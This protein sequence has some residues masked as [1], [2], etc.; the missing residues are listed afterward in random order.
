VN[1]TILTVNTGSS[2]I[3]LD[4]FRADATS[5][6][7]LEASVTDIGLPAS[8]VNVRIL[9]REVQT[10]K[11]AIAD[12]AAAA[13]VLLAQLAKSTALY[14]IAAIGYR[15][16]HGGSAYS[17]PQL[18]TDTVEQQLQSFAAYDP[19]HAP[20][21]L[22]LIHLLRQRFPDVP[23]VACFDTVFSHDMPRVAQLLPLP[24]KYEAMGLRRYG[25]HGLSYTYLLEAFR[26]AAGA[27]AADGRVIFAHLGSGASLMATHG[28]KPVDTTMGF[29]P[30]SG[31]VMSS[32]SGD[33]DPGILGYL[34]EQTGMSI[35]QYNHMINFESGLLGVSDLS[36]DM[37]TLLEHEATNPQA[38]EAVNLFVYQ[39]KKAIGA[40]A[41][42]LGGLDSLIFSGGIGEQSSILRAR[43][44]EGLDFLGIELNP[45]NNQRHAELIS[46]PAGRVGVH[47]IS[48]DEARTISEQVMQTLNGHPAQHE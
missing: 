19:Q 48:T 31:V 41:T 21:A 42:T 36:A 35:E 1:K 40:L 4:L 18:I 5:V 29:T 38:A 24:R 47:V 27:A 37:R 46:A 34:H 8:V 15:V 11:L 26:T 20:A 3:K 12:H 30:A 32:R 9:P 28:G 39:I 17:Q 10:Q 13:D 14:N 33:L 16:V 43:I 45:V 6:R 7:V 2:S 22:H 23:Q 25:F 44:A